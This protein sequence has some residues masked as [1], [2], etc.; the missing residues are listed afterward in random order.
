MNK[1]DLMNKYKD[2]KVLCVDNLHLNSWNKTVEDNTEAL[3]NA[4]SHHGYFNFRYNAELDFNAR[5]V[6]PYV[7]LKHKNEYFV[8]KRI[9]G[10]ERLVGGLSIAVG[11]HVNLCDME[12]SLQDPMPMITNCILRELAEETTFDLDKYQGMQFETTFVDNSTEVS[13]VHVCLLT[14]VELKDKEIEVKE[15]EKL[16]GEWMNGTQI[17]DNLDKFES[18]SKIT[19]GL[20]NIKPVRKPRKVKE[21]ATEEV[22][23]DSE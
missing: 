19:I 15:T 1:Q 10:D 3:V 12:T 22:A 2:E 20:L 6:I 11:G 21:V 7:V 9:K 5:Q 8:T 23:V 18:W 17:L 16:A 13:K 4:I 14:V